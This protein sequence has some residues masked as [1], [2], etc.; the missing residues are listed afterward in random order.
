VA[1]NVTTLCFS[2]RFVPAEVLEAFL[3]QTPRLSTLIYD[4]R[5]VCTGALPL[6]ILRQGLNHIQDSLTTLVVRYGNY[7]D[8]FLDTEPFVGVIDGSL[9]SLRK[10][11]SLTNLKIPLAVLYGR[12]TPPSDALPLVEM[13]PLNLEHL[14]IPNGSW[15]DEAFI[16]HHM[17]PFLAGLCRTATPHLQEFVLDSSDSYWVKP[18]SGPSYNPEIDLGDLCKRQGLKFTHRRG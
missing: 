17:R 13:L 16:L 11:S 8:A 5:S 18:G 12:D 4:C 10:F 14:T 2:R 7:V 6:S 15:N 9:G 1:R 3:Q